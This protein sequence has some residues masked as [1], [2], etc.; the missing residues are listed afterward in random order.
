MKHKGCKRWLARRRQNEGMSF[1]S[2]MTKHRSLLASGAPLKRRAK[3]GAIKALL[4]VTIQGRLRVKLGRERVAP[5]K[6]GLPAGGEVIGILAGNRWQSHEKK[7][8]RLPGKKKA[9]R[10][11]LRLHNC[12]DR[13]NR[14]C[15]IVSCQGDGIQSC[16]KLEGATL[17][18]VSTKTYGSRRRNFSSRCCM[19]W[20]EA[21]RG[22]SALLAVEKE[23]FFLE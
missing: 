4:A 10:K 6:T 14:A 17:K 7:K 5:V 13:N 8:I 21:A 22:P 20:K 1:R 18:V 11:A 9:K 19:T 15:G 2:L 3:A 12:P 16:W 23:G